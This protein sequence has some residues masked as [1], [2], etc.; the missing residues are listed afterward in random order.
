[1]YLF[2]K[3]SVLTRLVIMCMKYSCSIVGK[4]GILIVFKFRLQV[5]GQSGVQNRPYRADSGTRVVIPSTMHD[6]T[7]TNTNGDL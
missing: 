2:V 1:M 7:N 3:F 4:L 5:S 6:S